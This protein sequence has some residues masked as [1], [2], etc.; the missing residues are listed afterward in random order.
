MDLELHGLFIHLVRLGIGSSDDLCIPDTIDWKALEAV[1]N[2]Q[3]LLDIVVDGIDRL[4]LSI[5]P[6][7][8]ALLQLIRQTQ[9]KEYQYA[10]Q[11]KTA[12]EMAIL[13]YHHGIKTYVLK[14]AVVAECYPKPSHRVSVDMDCYVLPTD[15]NADVWEKAN[16]TIEDAGFD[17]DRGYYKNS[18]FYLP[19][20]NVENHRFITPFRGNKSLKRLEKLL[21]SLM[22]EDK[23]E[24]FF[25]WTRLLR[26]P[27]MVSALFL[28]EHSYSHFLHEGLTW[29]HILDWM[30]FSKRHNNELDWYEFE[31]RVNEFGLRKFYDSY[32]RLGRFLVGEIGDVSLSENDRLMLADVWMSL[33]LHETVRGVKGKLSLAGNTWRARWKYKYFTDISWIRALWIQVKGFI[34]LS[35]PRL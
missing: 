1:A 27:L 26:P 11:Q 21:Q 12:A 20:L 23:G 3:G 2:E 17:V 13:L 7:K 35:H 32:A 16:K 34:F 5:R 14:G 18:T 8:K 31:E 15:G 28:I 4:P 25:E 30:M 24:D 6:E 33:D 22:V 10:V 29:R 19:G 9:Q